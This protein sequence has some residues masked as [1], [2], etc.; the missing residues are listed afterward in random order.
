[1][2]NRTMAKSTN[3]VKRKAG[4]PVEIVGGATE[5]VGLRLPSTLLKRVD[6]RAKREKLTRSE[7]TRAA[8]EQWAKGSK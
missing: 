3:I 6:E 5:F 7:A 1:M 2:L 4:R 8:L